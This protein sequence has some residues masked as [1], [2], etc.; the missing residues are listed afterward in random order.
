VKGASIRYI[1]LSSGFDHFW[2]PA[3]CWAVFAVAGL[4]LH[5][6]GRLPVVAR[7]Y[8][9]F[10]LPLTGGVLAAYA[11]LDDTA[12]EL[13][14]STP[15]PA[16]RTLLERLGFILVVQGI[17]AG[18][19]QVLAGAMGD[20]LSVLGSR[21]PAQL[22]WMVPT[23]ALMAAGCLVAL[24]SR[25]PMTGALAAGLIWMVEVIAH[26]SFLH[27]S[28]ARHLFLFMGVMTPGDPTLHANQWTLVVLCLVFLVAAWLLLRRQER[29]L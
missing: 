3:S 22:A 4:V 6:S 27:S 1:V 7:A 25:R 29:Y 26:T 16:W 24:A 18:G 2:F 5:D 14:F 11:V 9:G 8:L 28:W 23:L 21:G 10:A 15:M 12:L 19:Y 13:R 20:D 17:C